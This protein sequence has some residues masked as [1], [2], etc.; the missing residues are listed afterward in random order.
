MIEEG[1]TLVQSGH[2]YV[3]NK[4]Q[5]GSKGTCKFIVAFACLEKHL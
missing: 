4:P 5:N 2:F 1:A 3:Q